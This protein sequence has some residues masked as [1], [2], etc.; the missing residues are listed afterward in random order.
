MIWSLDGI[1]NTF[2]N[3]G[4]YFAFYD[5]IHF[6]M[7]KVKLIMDESFMPTHQDM[8]RTRVRTTGI[9]S[10]KY[11]FKEYKFTIWDLGAERNER[12]RYILYTK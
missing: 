7:D 4:Y 1:K 9:I 6:F 11:E 2:N 8:L 12:F 10:H 3:R 5:N